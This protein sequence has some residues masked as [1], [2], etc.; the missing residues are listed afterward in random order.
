MRILI[1]GLTTRA[2]A[3]SAVGAGHDVLTVDYFGDLDQK[4]IC[5]NVSL[6]ERGLN[7]SADALLEVAADLSFDAVVYC[8]GLENHPDAVAQ[9]ARGKAL[10]GNGPDTLRRVRDPATVLPFL[11]ARGFEVPRTLESAPTT[12]LAQ[13]DAGTWL[14]KPAAGGGGQGIRIWRGQLLRSR[15]ILQERITGIPA[16]VAFV[17]DG[18]QV[19]LLGWS[20]QLPGPGF[21]YGGNLLPIDA[22]TAVW[23]ELR[24]IAGALTAEF[25]LVGLNGVDFILR[26]ARPVVL[27]VNPRYTASMELVELA[28]G[29][30]VF[31]IHVAACQEDLAVA[32]GVGAKLPARGDERYWGKSIVYADATVE[33]R[34]PALWIERGVHD[35]PRPGAAIRKGHPIC[36]VLASGPSRDV[37][38]S[39]LRAQA[40]TVRAECA[41][42]PSDPTSAAQV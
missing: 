15:Q 3:E 34:E 23:E 8:G 39:R 37:C 26:D 32:R 17:S 22:P 38:L 33:V 20:E 5:P 27:E 6:C 1:V 35:V 21:R 25:G 19:V 18:R 24:D 31:E 4:R 30:R 13:A 16:S 40:A 7:Y 41:R 42:L 28:L 12:E 11:A 36:T 10:L 14:V 2:I 29:V 9:L